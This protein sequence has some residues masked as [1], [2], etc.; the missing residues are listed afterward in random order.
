MARRRAS[1]LDQ[2]LEAWARW[3]AQPEGSAAPRS[4]LARWM[5]AKGHLIFGGGA[6]GAPVLDLLEARIELAVRALGQA[7]PLAED[8]LRLE[9]AAGW[10][11]VVARRGLRGYDPRGLTQL[12][13]ALHLGVS[14]RTYRLRLAEARAHVAEHIGGKP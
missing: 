6:P 7:N 4:L 2:Q 5:D 3:L 13:Q 10:R 12:Q 14:V 11:L 8:A 9:Y 1:R